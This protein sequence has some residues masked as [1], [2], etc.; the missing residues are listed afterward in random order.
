MDAA[1]WMECA[2]PDPKGG[3]QY[4]HLK[5]GR[6]GRGAV[7]CCKQVSGTKTFWLQVYE[8]PQ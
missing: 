7:V 1:T 8:L 3:L 2:A 5:C 6:V 4:V